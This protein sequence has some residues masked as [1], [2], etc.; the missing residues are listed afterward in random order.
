M[1]RAILTWLFGALL[2]GVVSCSP[3]AFSMA[4][5]MRQPS[6]SGLDLAG[7]SF[8]VVY[9]LNDQDQTNLF[10]ANFANGFAE[11]LEDEYFGGRRRVSLFSIAKQEDA[12]DASKDTLV[13]LVMDVNADVV[14]LVDTPAFGT[15]DSEKLPFS[16]NVFAYDSMNRAED[17]V[18]A[19]SGSNT[20]EVKDWDSSCRKAGYE[21]G[22]IFAPQWESERF[23]VIYFDGG[24]LWEKASTAAAS[25][26]WS[27]AIDCWLQLADTDNVQKRS[28]AEYDLALGCFMEGQYQLALE[29]LDRSDADMPVYMSKDLRK[30]IIE[31]MK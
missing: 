22:N 1:K 6:R 14:F 19:Y 30:K 5:D 7:K 15:Q 10:N 18:Y 24:G 29:W 26:Q 20:V 9:L 12:K 31:R 4:V 27:D 3:Q 21:A 25:F 28:C 23:S 8:A 13:N 16:V 17:K 11:K 2:L